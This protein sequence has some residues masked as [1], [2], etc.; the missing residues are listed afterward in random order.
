MPATDP[1]IALSGVSKQFQLGAASLSGIFGSKKGPVFHALSDVSFDIRPGETVGFLGTNGAGKSTLLQLIAGTLQPTSG[2]IAVKG[3]VSALLELGAGFNPEWTG[4]HNAEFYCRVQGAEAADIPALIENII[5]FAQIGDFFD[6]PMRTYSS[7]MFLRVAF[8]AAVAIDPDIVIVDEALAV[9]D[10]RFQNKCFERFKE[11]QR[12]GKTILF[13]THDTVMMSKFCTRGIVL[14]GG[15]I[16]LDGPPDVAVSTYREILYGSEA[17]SAPPPDMPRKTIRQQLTQS[18]LDGSAA[19]HFADAV[20]A[21]FSWPPDPNL[22]AGRSHYNVHA[23]SAG[24]GIGSITDVQLLDAELKPCQPLIE[25]GER[26]SIAFQ[27]MTDRFIARPCYGIVIKSRENTY[28]YGI[29]NIMLGIEMPSIARGETISVCFEIDTNIASGEYF[30]DAGFSEMSN[31]ELAVLEW[32]MSV[33]CFSVRARQEIYGIVDLKAKFSV[34]QPIV[35][36][37]P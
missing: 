21:A 5:D 3:R 31:D 29:T 10:A 18:P 20:A 35:Q 28:V 36:L 1:S 30:V 27:V 14:K 34:G 23:S 17:E 16:V 37:L 6:Q 15:R 7:G 9:G 8:A 2:S 4:R 11:L 33:A 19:P 25:Q 12:A 24:L 32:R 13:V 26:L 22:L